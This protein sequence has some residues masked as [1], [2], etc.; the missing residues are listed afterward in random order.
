VTPDQVGDGS[1]D[2]AACS[3]CGKGP[4]EVDRLIAGPEVWICDGCVRACYEILEQAGPRATPTSDERPATSDAVMAA[5]EAAQQAALRGERARA[6]ELFG[7]LWERIGDDG[8]PL[9]RVTLAHFMADVQDD[10]ADE[11]E[12]DRRALAAAGVLTDDRAAS[13]SPLLSVR[14]MLPSLHASLAADYA[15]LGRLDEAREQLSLAEAAE[16]DLPDG[17]Y[18]DLVRSVIAGLRERLVTGG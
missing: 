2:E 3:F 1:V 4:S 6:R 13:Y 17:G 5:I 15:G 14:G 7:E 18:G 9:H 16:P 11:L 10:P 8:D 12:W